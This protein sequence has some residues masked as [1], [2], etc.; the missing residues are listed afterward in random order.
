MCEGCPGAGHPEEGHGSFR[1]P[2]ECRLHQPGPGDSQLFIS[3]H[4]MFQESLII[5]VIAVP[6]IFQF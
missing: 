6:T 4:R 3:R 5:S 1:V 2:S